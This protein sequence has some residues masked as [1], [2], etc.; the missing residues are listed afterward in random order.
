[1]KYLIFQGNPS[2][3]NK[4]RYRTS[5]I[6]KGDYGPGNADGKKA[7]SQNH[8]GERKTDPNYIQGFP[9][10][11]TLSGKHWAALECKRKEHAHVQ[12]NQ[13]YYI[14]ILDRMSF[15]SFITPEMKE[16][17]LNAM[18]RSFQS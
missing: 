3:G 16:E 2:P 12:P 8:T 7:E 6:C 10:L 14:D 13:E 5:D 15:A 17:V 1:M 9:D 18:E 11:L 4:K